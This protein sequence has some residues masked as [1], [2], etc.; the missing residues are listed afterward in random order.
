MRDPNF[1]LIIIVVVY[2]N[3][4]ILGLLKEEVYEAYMVNINF[5]MI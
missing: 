3:L 5:K 2:I 1:L 4:K